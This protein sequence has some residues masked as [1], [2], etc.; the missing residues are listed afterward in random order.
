MAVASVSIDKYNKPGSE[1]FIFLLTTC[2]GGLGIN[3]TT[4]DVVVLYDSDCKTEI[5]ILIYV[6]GSKYFIYDCAI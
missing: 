3:L 1:D 2:A 4:A 6:F 5:E